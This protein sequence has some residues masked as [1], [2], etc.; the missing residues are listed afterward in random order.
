MNS[1]LDQPILF[2]TTADADRSREFYESMLGL[3]FVC[4]EPY[5]LV[6]M[7]GDVA[8]RI[9]KVDAVTAAAHTVLGWSVPD[10]E[11]S[12]QSLAEKGVQFRR[13]Q[14]IQQDDAGVWESPGGSKVAWFADPDGNILSLTQS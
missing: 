8:L 1:A 5:A 7:V 2:L 9:Q 12:V 10:I 4:D 3:S 6:F 14:H 11:E 13:Y